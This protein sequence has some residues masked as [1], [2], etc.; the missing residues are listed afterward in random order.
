MDNGSESDLESDTEVLRKYPESE[1]DKDSKS[2]LDS[3]LDSD[4]ESGTE[5]YSESDTDKGSTKF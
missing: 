4:T 2:C 1:A 3:G 5:R